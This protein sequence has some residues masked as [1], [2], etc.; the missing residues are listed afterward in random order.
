MASDGAIRSRTSPEVF[1][2]L[3]SGNKDCLLTLTHTETKH[4]S[5]NSY[6]IGIWGTNRI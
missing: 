1:M 2:F 5:Q 4:I 3:R 6:W